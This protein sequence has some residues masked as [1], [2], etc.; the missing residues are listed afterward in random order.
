VAFGGPLLPTGGLTA[1]PGGRRATA[2]RRQVGS[3]VRH[4]FADRFA[5][6]DRLAE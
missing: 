5:E 4:P 2:A 3:D 1:G 6:K